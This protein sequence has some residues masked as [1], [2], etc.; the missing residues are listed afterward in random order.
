ME[1]FCLTA[2]EAAL[3]KTLAISNGLA[4]LQNT[5]G[6][7]GVCIEGDATTI[8]WQKNALDH[9]FSIMENE[10][11]RENLIQQNYEWA[12][13]MSWESRAGKLLNDY[14]FVH[15]LEYRGMLNWTNDVPLN[16]NARAIF[17]KNILRFREGRSDAATAAAIQVLE[18]GTYTGTSIIELMKLIPDS[19]GVALDKW[20]N[21]EETSNNE[22]LSILQNMEQNNIENVFYRNVKTAGLENRISSIKGDSSEILMKF[23]KE[24]RMFDFI[25]VD[26]SHKCLDV[27]LD[28]FLSWNLLQKG[29]MM[30]IDDYLYNYDKFTELPFEYPFE[31]VNHF[32][33]KFANEMIVLD[34][35]Y[36]VFIEKLLE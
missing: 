22:V 32:L 9:L 5:I 4:A 35:G 13:T 6:D 27:T 30:V 15:K 16:T 24:N 29:G 21:Y 19:Y 34:K 26:G 7:R 33:N 8:E 36:R 18:I 20:T 11:K 23:T 12:S 10:S 1:T 14:I 31:A 3:S 28:L 2:L 25:Y 17:E